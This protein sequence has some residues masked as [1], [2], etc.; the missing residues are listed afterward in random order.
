MPTSHTQTGRWRLAVGLGAL[1]S[2]TS[3]GV[4]LFLGSGSSDGP[5][6]RPTSRVD[7]LGS[8]R[9][10][11]V[12]LG[13]PTAHLVVVMLE[14]KEYS[15]VIANTAAPYLNGVLVP[16][17]KLF[18]MHYASTHPSLPN[19]LVLTSGQYGGCVVDNC[20]VGSMTGPNIFSQMNGA[21][22]PITW[23]VYAEGMPS[24]CYG[25]NANN[26]Y[27]VRHNPPVYYSNLTAGDNSCATRNVPLSGLSADVQQGGLPDFAMVIP[28]QWNDMHT[29]RK[30]APCLL[31]S[32]VQDTVCQGDNWLA[33]W[34]PVLLSDGGLNDTTVLITFDE[35]T[36]SQGGAGRVVLLEVGPGTCSGCTDASPSNHYGLSNALEQWFGLAPLYPR[37]PQ[38]APGPASARV[39]G[40]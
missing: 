23:K 15:Q 35:G 17:G 20:P 10:S 9:A 14:N 12:A 40:A 38:I 32:T 28:N 30:Q 4:G 33:E 2:M 19:Y 18:T 39:G 1:V 8:S 13:T 25:R 31:G 26:G 27:V 11:Q 5:T 24:N 7:S 29:D 22:I 21:T 3:L 37:V 6:V 36:T 16:G 34:I